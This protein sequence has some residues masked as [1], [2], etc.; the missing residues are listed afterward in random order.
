MF[1]VLH[2][3]TFDGLDIVIFF[4]NFIELVQLL[5]M[6]LKENNSLLEVEWEM[7]L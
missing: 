6:K 5:T 3:P 1:D 7:V 2:E 4:Y